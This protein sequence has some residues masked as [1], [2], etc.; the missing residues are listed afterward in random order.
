M[1]SFTRI[2]EFLIDLVRGSLGVA[3]ARQPARTYAPAY[4]KIPR[5]AQAR[6]RRER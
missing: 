4:A 1:N 2:V 3:A 5:R 6:P